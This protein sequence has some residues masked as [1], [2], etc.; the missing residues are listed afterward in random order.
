MATHD[1]F[2][3]LTE[4]PVDFELKQYKMMAVLSRLKKE[5]S[6][7]N[8]W[9]VIEEVEAQLDY[10]YRMKYEIEICD[11]KLK[12][13]KDIDFINFEIIY[14]KEM[15]DSVIENEIM[16]TIVDEG[17]VEFGDL[18]MDAR[19]SWR[20]VEKQIALTWVPKRPPLLNDGYVFIPNGELMYAYYFEKPTKMSN[21]WRKL[22]LQ[23]HATF[24]NTQDELLKFYDQTQNEKETLM[25][26]RISI[27]APGIPHQTAVL[28]VVKSVLFNALVKD[29]A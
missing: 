5:L 12:V 4:G 25:F 8:I 24:D 20:D 6:Y 17:I 21:S 2:S 19:E 9:P 15:S 1:R 23:L 28:P 26:S 11:E 14:E 27:A 18:Y 13:A 29:F 7:Y 22:D 10:L 16:D 3:W